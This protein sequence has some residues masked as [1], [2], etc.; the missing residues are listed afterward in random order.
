[1]KNPKGCWRMCVGATLALFCVVGLTINA[2]SVYLPYL[3]E[4]CSLTNTQ[5]SNVLLVRSLFAFAAL[6]FVGVYYDKLEI[7]LGMTV[8]T[9]LGAA[10]LGLYAVAT[11]FGGLCLA[12]AVGGLAYGLGG[13]YPASLL[14][15]RWFPYHG[16]LALGICTAS[17]G[18][19][20]IVGA[21]AVTALIEG[22][23]LHFALLSEASLLLGCAA[24]S[25][26]VIRNWPAGAVKPEKTLKKRSKF[27]LN[28]MFIAVIAIGILG[29]TGFQFLPMHY[30][31]QGFGAYEV[32]ALVSLVGAALTASKF[33]FG[34]A[35]DRWGAFR[36]N[37]IFGG[38]TI[39]GCLLCTVGRGYPVALCAMVL[40][41]LGLSFTT[42]GLTVYARDLAAPEDFESTVQQYQIAYLLGA[43]LFGSVPGVLADRTGDFRLY[44]AL[45]TGLTVFAVAVVQAHYLKKR[46]RQSS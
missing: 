33:L 36:A 2:F 6:L 41:G 29:N 12:A 42:V 20:T 35:S 32:S 16:A 17:T 28:W 8:A 27:R 24:V 21:P 7:R 14:I 26:L 30:K 18:I 39:L 19:A 43:L 40:L 1:M 11:S 31:N 45:V 25:F 37:W 38:L 4:K 10:S 34:E 46:A 13:M 9:L 22:V 44:Y 3:L 5:S 15:H 23:S